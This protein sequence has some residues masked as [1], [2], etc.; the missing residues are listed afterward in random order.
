MLTSFFMNNPGKHTV[1]LFYKDLGSASIDKLR[2]TIDRF[3]SCLQDIKIEED[4]FANKPLTAHFTTEVYYRILVYKLIPET[5]DRV[6]WIDS[7]M[8][9]NYDIEDLYYCDLQGK[10]I[11]ACKN[12]SGNDNARRIGL[13]TNDRYFNSGL[14][15][16]DLERIRN[17][18]TDE[19][20]N[21]CFE[22]LEGKIQNPDQDVLN[23]MYRDNVLY[24]DPEIYNNQFY[25]PGLITKEQIIIISQKTKIIHYVTSH[26]P[27]HYLYASELDYFYLKYIKEISII[28]Y[29]KLKSIHSVC[30]IIN[31]FRK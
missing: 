11:G 25:E 22:L 23:I 13:D 27:W 29:I 30:R 17:Q 14:I 19:Y 26:K 1:F 4:F 28:D 21:S 16:F 6:L 15:L 12:C 3:N 9:I 31:F 20:V 7:D 10:L 18:I 8:I 24:F 2:N 5:I